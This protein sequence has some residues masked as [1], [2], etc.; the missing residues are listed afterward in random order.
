MAKKS[1]GSELAARFTRFADELEKTDD[2]EKRFTMRGARIAEPPP[3][4]PK[5]IRQTRQLLHASQ[6]VF[7]GLLGV[8]VASFRDWEQGVNEPPGSACRLMTAIRMQP[9][10]WTDQLR[11]LVAPRAARSNKPVRHQQAKA[12]PRRTVA[13]RSSSASRTNRKP[14]STL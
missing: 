8:S 12:T 14:K 1:V 11:S 7:A 13:Q 2:P 9:E 4:G 10:F 6:P 5:L 3:H